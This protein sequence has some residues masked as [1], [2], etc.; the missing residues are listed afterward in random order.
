MKNTGELVPAT[1]NPEIKVF[2]RF[3]NLEEA[4]VLEQELIGEFN[5]RAKEIANEG[6]NNE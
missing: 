4:K 5:E 1:K 3:N 2:K 6:R